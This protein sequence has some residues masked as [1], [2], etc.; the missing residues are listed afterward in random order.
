[1]HGLYQ[2][3]LR[4]RIPQNVVPMV[5]KQNG[6]CYTVRDRGNFV[7]GQNT[8]FNFTYTQYTRYIIPLENMPTSRS[9]LG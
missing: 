8:Q 7:Y 9:S 6:S 4:I 1:M 5:E 2:V 3:S